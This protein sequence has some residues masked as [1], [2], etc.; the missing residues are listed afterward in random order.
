MTPLLTLV[1][2]FKSSA[3]IGLIMAVNIDPLVAG[4]TI[5]MAG[6]LIWLG[7]R[8]IG[9]LRKQ[10]EQASEQVERLDKSLSLAEKS[11]RAQLI[12]QLNIRYEDIVDA[13][14]DAWNIFKEC[15]NRY[16]TDSA[17]CYLAISKILSKMRASEQKADIVR[18]YNLRKLLDFGELVG[19]LIIDRELLTIDDIKNLWGPPLKIWAE[20]FKLH[21]E[22]LQ[23]DFPGSYDLLIKLANKL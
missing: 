5:V 19:F 18:Y 1:D 9:A 10:I 2:T 6:G 13:R 4:A 12:T 22:D 20:W 7:W 16:P 8:Q 21:I 23:K 15:K 17:K 3:I 14:R 11:S